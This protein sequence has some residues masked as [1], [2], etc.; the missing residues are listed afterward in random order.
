MKKNKAYKFRIYPNDSQKVLILK[1]FGCSRFIYN[2]L[3]SDKSEYYKETKKSLK[4]LEFYYK[5]IPDYAF[6]KEVDSLAL[7]NSRRNLEGAFER[8]FK[9]QSKYP[10][11]KCKGK[12]DS[13]TTNNQCYGKE[14]DK[15]T[16][17]FTSDGLKLPKLGVVK[18]K[19]HRKLKDNET[20]KSVTISRSGNSYYASILVEYEAD[21]ILPVFDVSPD[22]VIGFDFSVP[23]FAVDSNGILIDMPHWYRES[24]EKLAREQ[25]KLSKKI[26]VFNKAN[27]GKKYVPS[28]N[29]IKQ[30][31]KVQKIANHVANQR[32]DFIH[33]LTRELMNSDYKVFAFEDINLQNMSQCLNLGKSVM[34][35]GFGMFRDILKYKAENEG[36]CFVKIDKW[37]ASTK[38]CSHCGHK[39]DKITLKT[40][41]WTCPE[42][43]IKHNRD[44]NAA[45]NIKN[46][47][48][49]VWKTLQ[50]SQVA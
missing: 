9:N 50:P 8:F 1:T 23:H 36:K 25:R 18:I 37:Y 43:N 34:D 6:L 2:H 40:Q 19:Q 32:K 33:K 4:R 15:F 31:R 11:F 38:T 28:N 30:Q 26:D 14:K 46:E 44:H 49:R 7:M 24:Q 12:K 5:K 39:N 41:E 20:I 3:L 27:P 21:E 13:Y 45:I 35:N 29:F 10:K 22:E 47:G 16:I 42:C 48:Y 17:E